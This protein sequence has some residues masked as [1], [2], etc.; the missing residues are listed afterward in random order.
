MCQSKANGGKRCFNH[1]FK[2][3]LK[4]GIKKEN[5]PAGK[6]AQIEILYTLVGR[7]ALAK[8]IAE[9][10]EPHTEL[11]AVWNHIEE[12]RTTL[13]YQTRNVRGPSA[14]QA[15]SVTSTH[16]KDLLHEVAFRLFKKG[17]PLHERALATLQKENQTI[18]GYRHKVQQ[19]KLVY[20]THEVA[21]RLNVDAQEFSSDVIAYDI[22]TDTSRGYGLRAHKAQITEIVLS[23]RGESIVLAG[24]EKY[25]LT[26]FANYMNSLDRSKTLVGWNNRGFDNLFLDFRARHHGIENWGATLIDIEEDGPYP[27]ISGFN[28]R[29][30]LAWVS[31]EGVRHDDRDIFQEVYEQNG[32][33]ARGLKPHARS[34]GAT[35]IV[36][37][38]N[39]MHVLSEDERKA[40]TLS[41][42]IMTLFVESKSAR[43]ALW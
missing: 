41:D 30:A 34:L 24:D 20:D 8:M 9:S 6:E 26:E 13:P 27:P 28:H 43:P 33:V 4:S 1:V 25:I 36:V 5:F 7:R 19:D 11:L 38:R 14:E 18:S 29:A 2:N 40:Y 3:A 15:N 39:N 42:G 16:D 22:E 23:S 32:N 12:Y 17:G 37:D 31:P 10:P 21:A 35:P